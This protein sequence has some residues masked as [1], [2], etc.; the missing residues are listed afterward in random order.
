MRNL[1][2]TQNE[3]IE[4]INEECNDA[5]HDTS[6]TL[7]SP[8]DGLLAM[9]DRVTRSEYMDLAPLVVDGLISD[10]IDGN[11]VPLPS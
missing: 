7:S 10:P 4:N 9:K 11:A 8:K 5:T 6:I 2:V 1:E 3:L